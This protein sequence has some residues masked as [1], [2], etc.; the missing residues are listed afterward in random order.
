LIRI[1]AGGD[2]GFAAVAIPQFSNLR[3]RVI[4]RADVDQLVAPGCR[5]QPAGFLR[6]KPQLLA[7]D[8]IRGDVGGPGAEILQLERKYRNLDR[9]RRGRFGGPSRRERCKH[10]G[11]G[12]DKGDGAHGSPR[13]C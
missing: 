11:R 12:E 8:V 1:E 9:R 2:P 7:V 4:R 10:D 13:N 5:D 3:R 6:R